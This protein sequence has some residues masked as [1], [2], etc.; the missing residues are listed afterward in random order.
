VGTSNNNLIRVHCSHKVGT[1]I[2]GIFRTEGKGGDFEAIACEG[3]LK[4]FL[5]FHGTFRVGLAGVNVLAK[6]KY[7]IFHKGLSKRK[8]K[9][10]R[11][12]SGLKAVI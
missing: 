1:D 11:K 6:I 7:D 12:F 4:V 9:G 2:V 3:P 8:G 10:K 5:G